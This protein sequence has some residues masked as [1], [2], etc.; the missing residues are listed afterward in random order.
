MSLGEC[1]GVCMS[2]PKGKF[3][4]G[5]QRLM[6]FIQREG[7]VGLSDTEIS[8]TL[9]L[10]LRSI[11]RYLCDFAKQGDIEIKRKR[12]KSQNY[13]WHNARTIQYTKN[14]G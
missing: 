3:D 13:N 12:F 7:L 6:E 10:S 1:R 9:N 11:Q 8:S 5:R 2:R 14:E 4:P